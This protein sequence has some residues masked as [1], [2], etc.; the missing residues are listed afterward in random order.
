LPLKKEYREKFDEK[1]AWD[2]FNNKYVGL[3][4]GYSNFLF[5][6]LDTAE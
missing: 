6:W 2:A 3:P 5:G 1:K 4:Y